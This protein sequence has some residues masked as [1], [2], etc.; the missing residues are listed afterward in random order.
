MNHMRNGH[1]WLGMALVGALAGCD[2]SVLNTGP[3]GDD[4]LDDAGAHA[5]VVA[6][7]EYNISWALN[8]ITFFGAD[9]AK[10]LTQGGR[11]HP[12]KLTPN[13]GQLD[14][15][16][17]LPNDPWN[18]PH[19]ARWM[20]NDAVRRLQ[21]HL[22]T[23]SSSP[24]AAQA[25]LYAGYANRMLGENMCEAVRDSGP[26]EP[27][28]V[29]LQDAE[30]YFT[31]ALAVATAANRADYVNAARAGRA[32][33]RLWLGKDAEAASDAAA[34]P[35][36][37]RFDARYDAAPEAQRNWIYFI[38]SNTPYRAQSVWN[39]W[40]EPYF[41][42]TGDPRTAWRTVAGVPN[43]EFITV[44]Y[45]EQRKYTANTNPVRLSSG[46]EMVLVRAEVELR[47]GNWQQALTLINS[48][49]QGINNAAGQ[50]IPAWT[51]TNATEAWTAL[52]RER[53]I[54]LW[55]EGRRLGDLYRWVAAGTP[56]EMESVTDRIRLCF[57]VAQS[58]R[59]ANPNIPLD[60]E[61]PWN[62]L[63]QGS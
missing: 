20:A 31:E 63:F 1:R 61:S 25:L 36:A 19:R 17:Q 6:G 16:E 59:Q 43:A 29:H 3:V 37:F 8:M 47:A 48:L 5:A 41:T 24:L 11:I 14:I 27:R 21:E 58:E 60:H 35:L 62:P 34:V 18:R 50:P 33:V 23:F 40:Y 49:R 55:V 15:T 51:A 32:S 26:V 54:E 57:P 10:E 28:V 44:P 39:T 9:A 56:G 30:G 53:G 46:R 22:P 7:V 12:I 13:P 42:E 45:Y 52:K 38:N 2:L 4:V